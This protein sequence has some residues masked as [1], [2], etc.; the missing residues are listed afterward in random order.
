MYLILDSVQSLVDFTVLKFR[1]VSIL[2]LVQL[3][4][5]YLVRTSGRTADLHRT[6]RRLAYLALSFTRS[7]VTQRLLC[8]DPGFNSG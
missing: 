4:R 6:L 2:V 5:I 8:V 3:V 1:D 7:L